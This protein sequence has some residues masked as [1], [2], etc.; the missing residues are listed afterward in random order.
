MNLIVA[1]LSSYIA[2]RLLSTLPLILIFEITATDSS[3]HHVD[4]HTKLN[5]KLIGIGTAR[6]PESKGNCGVSLICLP[7]P[8]DAD[9]TYHSACPPGL[10]RMFVL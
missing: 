6:K 1:L 2:L 4:I 3:R 8:H 7:A 9:L 5:Y 10:P